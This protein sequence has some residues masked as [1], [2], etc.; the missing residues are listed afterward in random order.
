MLRAAAHVD[1]AM[2]DR[3]CD[4]VVAVFGVIRMYVECCEAMR[5]C[6]MVLRAA[7]WGE[8]VAVWC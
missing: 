1:W 4:L 7:V 5:N 6:F 3:E 2:N 8:S